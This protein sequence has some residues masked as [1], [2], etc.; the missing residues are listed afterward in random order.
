M[1]EKII[2]IKTCIECPFRISETR[3]GI[4]FVP[5]CN[6][7][8]IELPYVDAKK[9]VEPTAAATNVIPEWCP[10]EDEL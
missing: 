3:E 9:S 10:L 8:G 1:D 5:V 6:N 2:K 4:R 7:T